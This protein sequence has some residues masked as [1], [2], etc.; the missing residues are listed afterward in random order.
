MGSTLE[1]GISGVSDVNCAVIPKKYSAIDVEK[2]FNQPSLD[3]I[4]L[5]GVTNSGFGRY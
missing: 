2:S 4:R 5:A 3:V 1:N